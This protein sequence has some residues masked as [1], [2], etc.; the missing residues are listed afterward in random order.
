ML[1][2][3]TCSISAA[4]TLSTKPKLN[5]ININNPTVNLLIMPTVNL[6]MVISKSQSLPAN[7]NPYN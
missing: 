7:N 2:T 1:T 4:R 3:T 6:T 5:P